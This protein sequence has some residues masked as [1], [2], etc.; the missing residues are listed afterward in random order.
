MTTILIIIFS[1]GTLM[2][3]TVFYRSRLIPRWI[4]IW[5]FMAILLHLS[6]AALIVFRFATP[7]SEIVIAIN[8]PIFLQEMVMAVWL[9]V[10][11]FNSAAIAAQTTLNSGDQK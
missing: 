1:F 7:T 11:G 8:L 10:K 6:T 9:I 5:G 2:L 3:Y 4:S